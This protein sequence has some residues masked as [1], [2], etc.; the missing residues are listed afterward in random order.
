MV[1]AERFSNG[2]YYLTARGRSNTTSKPTKRHIWF[3]R[4]SINIG[5]VSLPNEFEGKRVAF[6]IVE[7]DEKGNEVT[8][9]E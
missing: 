7:I 9:N 1:K 2:Q 3:A 6:K 8:N 5:N 4:P